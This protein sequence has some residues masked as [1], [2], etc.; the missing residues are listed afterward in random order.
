MVPKY[1]A[2]QEGIWDLG[3]GVDI[4]KRGVNEVLHSL[5]TGTGKLS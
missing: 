2:S 5:A 3:K 4:N 1:E